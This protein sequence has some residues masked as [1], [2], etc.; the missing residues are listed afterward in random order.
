MN[1]LHHVILLGLVINLKW[2]GQRH[3]QAVYVEALSARPTKPTCPTC[4]LACKSAGELTR[5]S[6]IHEDV[7][8]PVTSNNRKFKCRICERTCKAVA[9][10]KRWSCCDQIKRCHFSD[11]K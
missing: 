2:H 5:Y 11:K 10:L 1:N 3:N 7:L 4:G 6:K 9:G 8:Q